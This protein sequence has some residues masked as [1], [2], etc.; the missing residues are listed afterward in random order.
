MV[1]VEILA[2]FLTLEEKLSVFIK[3]LNVFFS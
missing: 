2:L 3:M 1:S